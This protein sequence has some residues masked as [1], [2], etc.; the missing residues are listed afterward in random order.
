MTAWFKS[1]NPTWQAL[2]A[3]SAVFVVGATMA[4]AASGFVALPEAVQENTK[5]IDHL[6]E[7]MNEVEDA[8]RDILKAIR[9]SNC[10]A[11][12]QAKGEPWQQCSSE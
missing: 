9:F 3:L 5:N 12:A 1:L 6:A 11:L 4:L 2:L 8:Q 10:M 7:R